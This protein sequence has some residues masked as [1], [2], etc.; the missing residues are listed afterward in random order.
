ML[1]LAT[2]DRLSL[3]PEHLGILHLEGLGTFTARR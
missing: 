3:S 1:I 2:E